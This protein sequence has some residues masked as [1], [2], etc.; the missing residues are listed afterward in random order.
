MKTQPCPQCARVVPVHDGFVTW[1]ECGWNLENVDMAGG[2]K[3]PLDRINHALGQRS[4]Q[5]L[6]EDML[7][8]ASFRARFTPMLLLTWLMA[9]L[10]HFLTMC[11]I[12]FGAWFLWQIIVGQAS[13]LMVF[14]ALMLLGLGGLGLPQPSKLEEPILPQQEYPK[15]YALLERVAR[16]VGERRLPTLGVNTAF[17][18]YFGRFGWRQTPHIGLGLPLWTVLSA[19]ERV[20]LLAHELGHSVNGDHTRGFFC[21]AAAQTLY[22]WWSV[23]NPK[24]SFE[25]AYQQNPLV[26]F[27]SLPLMP[28]FYLV[29]ALIFALMFALNWAGFYNSRRAEYQADAISAQVAGK[30]AAIGLEWK[31]L[32]SPTMQ[33]A[34]QR[35]VLER[36]EDFFAVFVQVRQGVP[37]RELERLRRVSALVGTRLDH[38]HPQNADRQRFLHALSLKEPLVVLSEAENA[39]IDAELERLKPQ[40]ARRVISLFR[41]WMYVG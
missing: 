10:V 30:H 31:M 2:P 12:V 14:V 8:G 13:L 17:N 20:A 26:A 35:T 3:T 22:R 1:C 5:R 38:T 32:L 29:Q 23:S 24:T 27:L 6:L 16:A 18:A 41:D 19:Q 40:V 4:G 9:L 39:A 25:V 37:E 15:L 36:R 7:N 28:I 34:T 11:A 21:G 33:E